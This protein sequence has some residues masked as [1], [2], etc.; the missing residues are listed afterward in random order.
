MTDSKKK[1]KKI[2]IMLLKA[3]EKKSRLIVLDYYAG[4]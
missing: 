3:E 2:E 1:I 4:K